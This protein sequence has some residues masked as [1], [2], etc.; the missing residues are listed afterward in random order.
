MLRCH[1]GSLFN[2]PPP[3]SSSLLSSAA[4]TRTK[5]LRDKVRAKRQQQ[6]A[7]DSAATAAMQPANYNYN[8][9]QPTHLSATHP[10][11]HQHT[12]SHSHPPHPHSHP[13]AAGS[14]SHDGHD[15][16][17][18]HSVLPSVHEVQQPAAVAPSQPTTSTALTLEE[19]DIKM[20]FDGARLGLLD[21]LASLL[22]TGHITPQH[23]DQAFLIAA[24]HGHQRL[25]SLLLPKVSS[26]IARTPR[27]D[28]ALHLSAAHG[29]YDIVDLLCKVSTGTAIEERNNAGQTPLYVAVDNNQAHVVA[30]LLEKGAKVNAA[31]AARNSILHVAAA[32]GYAPIVLMVLKAGAVLTGMNDKDE[33]ALEVSKNSEICR[34]LLEFTTATLTLDPPSSTPSLSSHPATSPHILSPHLPT[35]I[36]PFRELPSGPSSYLFWTAMGVGKDSYMFQNFGVFPFDR[37]NDTERIIVLTEVAEA[38][39][40]YKTDLKGN[41]LNESALYAVFA[42]MKA[43]IK[44]ELEDGE[45][46]E[47]DEQE[48]V[49]WRKRVLEAYQQVYGVDA[50]VCGLSLDCFKR[51]VWNTVV[52]LLARSLFGESFW[53][54]KRMFLSPNG[55]ERTSLLRHYRVDVDYFHCRLPNTASVEIQLTFKKLIT[56]SKT[57]LCDDSERTSSRPP[58]AGC[59]CQECIAELEVP[60]TFKLQFLEEA[61]AEKRKMKKGRKGTGS[62]GGGGQP[63]LS[64]GNGTA[65]NNSTAVTVA[66]K[67]NHKSATSSTALTPSHSTHSA[68]SP[69]S[70]PSSSSLAAATAVDTTRSK[71]DDLII[72]QRKELSNFFC[73]PAVD[74]EILTDRGFLSHA[75]VRSLLVSHC[76]LR[77]ACP[78]MRRPGEYALQYHSFGLNELIEAESE[79]LVE[80]RCE[81][82]GVDLLVTDNHRMLV[83]LGKAD[84]MAQQRWTLPYIRADEVVESKE[85]AIQLLCNASC[86]LSHVSEQRRPSFSDL[87]GL[88]SV[89][90]EDAFIELYSCWHTYGRVHEIRGSRVACFSVRSEAEGDEVEAAM[91]RLP[92]TRGETWWREK[93]RVE[94]GRRANP[95]MTGAESSEEEMEDDSCSNPGPI[96]HRF[97]ISHPRWVSYFVASRSWGTVKASKR[98]RPASRTITRRV[99]LSAESI[100][101][102]GSG[103]DSEGDSE[104]SIDEVQEEESEDGLAQWASCLD[105]HQLRLLIRGLHRCVGSPVNESQTSLFAESARQADDY[106]HLCLIAGYTAVSECEKKEGI[107]QWVVHYTTSDTA[108][109]P[110]LT[111]NPTTTHQSKHVRSLPSSPLTSVWCIS[112]PTNEHLLI[113]RRKHQSPASHYAS[114]PVIVGNSSISVEEKWLLTEMSTAELSEI[115]SQASEWETLRAALASY[116]QYAWEEDVLEI[117]DDCFAESDTRV[118]TDS[119]LLYVDEI[120]ARMR[121]GERVTYACY[122]VDSEAL[123]YR[124]GKLV[125]P[126][127]K[128]QQQLLCF[129]AEEQRECEG[130]EKEAMLRVTP[131]HRM[132]VRQP[133]QRRP[134]VVRASTLHTPCRCNSST[135]PCLHRSA[136]FS[137]LNSAQHGYV[138]PSRRE[139]RGRAVEVQRRAYLQVVGFALH[140]RHF[141]ATSTQHG[142][143][144]ASLT[145]TRLSPNERAWLIERCAVAGVDCHMSGEVAAVVLLPRSHQLSDDGANGECVSVTRA[146]SEDEVDSDVDSAF[147]DSDEDEQRSDDERGADSSR[148]PWWMLRLSAAE[149]R[150]VVDGL[151][152]ANGSMHRR[153]IS[154]HDAMFCERLMHAL[155]HCGFSPLCSLSDNAWTISWSDMADSSDDVDCS[156]LLLTAGGITSQPYSQSSDGRIWCISVDHPDHLIVAQRATRLNGRITRQWRPLITGN[157]VT[158]ADDM[159]EDGKGMSDMLEAML[160]AVETIKADELTPPPHHHTNPASTALVPSHTSHHPHQHHSHHHPHPSASSPLSDEEWDKRGRQMLENCVLAE[161]AR[162]V[163]AQYLLKKQ[164]SKAQQVALE[165]ELELLQEEM[166]VKKG[167]AGEKKKKKKAAKRKEKATAGAP[168]AEEAEGEADEEKEEAVVEMAEVKEEKTEETE[169]QRPTLA[170]EKDDEKDKERKSE[171]GR[172]ADKAEKE[173]REASKE[174]TKKGKEKEKKKKQRQNSTVTTLDRMLSSSSSS[175][176]KAKPA[177]SSSTSSSSASPASSLPV[178]AAPSPSSSAA[179]A[180][181]KEAAKLPPP[182]TAAVVN[183]FAMLDEQAVK[184]R[185]QQPSTTASSTQ[186]AVLSS[187]PSTVKRQSSETDDAD[188]MLTADGSAGDGLVDGLLLVITKDSYQSFLHSHQVGLSRQQFPIVRHLKPLRTAVL[189]F[190]ASDRSVHGVYQCTGLV[191]ENVNPSAFSGTRVKAG[192]GRSGG[193]GGI[194]GVGYS[195]WMELK[196]MDGMEV[197]VSE[198]VVRG[199]FGSDGLKA[200]KVDLKLVK[201]V[202]AAS[203]AQAGKR[204]EQ[205]GRQPATTQRPSAS[206]TGVVAVTSKSASATATAVT[207]PRTQPPVQQRQTSKQPAPPATPTTSATSSAAALPAAASTAAP[208][209][210]ASAA[211]NSDASKSTAAGPVKNVWK[212]RQE[213]KASEQQPSPSATSTASVG[214]IGSPLTATATAPIGSPLVAAVFGGG[215]IINPTIT[216]IPSSL[217]GSSWQ[218]SAQRAAAVNHSASAA[219]ATP[220]F[221][222]GQSWSAIAG[223]RVAA[224]GGAI[225]TVGAPASPPLATVRTLS[226]IMPISSVVPAPSMTHVPDFDIGQPA[227]AWLPPVTHQPP[228]QLIV[229]DISHT[230]HQHQQ[231]W[232]DEQ[233]Q[234]QQLM[235]GGHSVPASHSHPSSPLSSR[236]Y[237]SAYESASHDRLP[238]SAADAYVRTPPISPLRAVGSLASSNSFAPPM[239][240]PAASVPQLHIHSHSHTGL[241]THQHPHSMPPSP[242]NRSL[243]N[244]GMPPLH[245]SMVVGRP[246][247]PPSLMFAPMTVGYG[248]TPSP[249]PAFPPQQPM[250]HP[251]PPQLSHA[252]LPYSMPMAYQP[253]HAMYDEQRR[254]YEVEEERRFEAAEAIRQQQQQEEEREREMMRE[255]EREMAAAARYEEEMNRGMDGL[256]LHMY[257]PPAH[258]QLHQSPPPSHQPHIPHPHQLHSLAHFRPSPAPSIDVERDELD[259]RQLELEMQRR[260]EAAAAAS[261]PLRSTHGHF[262]QSPSP[263]SSASSNS[264]ATLS[265]LWG[266]STASTLSSSTWGSAVWSAT[267]ASHAHSSAMLNG[268]GS[269][270]GVREDKLDPWLQKDEPAITGGWASKPAAL[271]LSDF[272]GSSVSA[273]KST[274]SLLSSL[275]SIPNSYGSN[276]AGSSIWGTGGAE[277]SG[278]GGAGGGMGPNGGQAFAAPPLLVSPTSAGGM[279]GLKGKAMGGFSSDSMWSSS[280]QSGW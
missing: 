130:D 266:S 17:V 173:Q 272:T 62:G 58:T 144:A 249:H 255:R 215:V 121:R 116:A 217:Q 200:R 227:P 33:T 206:V 183:P 107:S 188:T 59:F 95:E 122:E 243:F 199:L 239:P 278:A 37:L 233:Q 258:M 137:M 91:H 140:D 80:F 92:L 136:P 47:A 131:S 154:T 32:N 5:Q 257:Q 41:L 126:P 259:V 153:Q 103:E 169:M 51:T 172:E 111:I 190:N 274:P 225:D 133:G 269:G 83:R 89:D 77:I 157:C 208:T 207:Q 20:F 34:L 81:A 181:A 244:S 84:A 263:T 132:L 99:P 230:Q 109:R 275:P 222:P 276:F 54:K 182:V 60:L 197:E 213:Q 128:R 71:L 162:K 247:P 102:L 203:K 7:A 50:G 88:T 232:M 256:Q 61:A 265:S 96:M 209:A 97:V 53:E 138:S 160:D 120:E 125:F 19:S 196:S 180:K 237:E 220:S 42:L 105:A 45:L 87:L 117:S 63:A 75:T 118:L 252:S 18:A 189:L 23:I 56:M 245:P 142:K 21:H 235:H 212:L 179:A 115:I 280:T 85:E 148:P 76:P 15:Y 66:G 27:G 147:T 253:Q 72:T 12:H 44:R 268:G 246:A 90:E 176:I 193:G 68:A 187:A 43:R 46:L 271:S 251:P 48:S 261:I 86:G 31:D 55:F 152:Y 250:Y 170:E 161:F 145:F 110:V 219:A 67:S 113:V 165:L 267:S 78:V 139:R 35:P 2:L 262:S 234:Q 114:R 178:S 185:V 202:A 223:A 254:Q 40:G 171:E 141:C 224:A 1:S 231:Q 69:R 236:S 108:A 221:A 79:R 16:H 166:A 248:R 151:H 64:A 112:V 104:E 65:G 93:T 241:S 106:V 204:K 94:G 30:L 167:K 134:R 100:Q 13:T 205:A 228:P 238:I 192:V 127:A 119:G 101:K 36:S 210:V 98:I 174:E 14:L 8:T 175:A 74:H 9:T 260:D 135:Q 29:H 3:S 186:Q 6:R 22:D 184:K 24:E 49:V 11:T 191:G 163:A 4:M 124:P 57:F 279:G 82:S 218:S 214:P 52:N 155:L 226:P 229:D 25:L 177:S 150:C 168:K 201:D 158:I 10:H 149:L 240:L 264:K 70:L 277:S 39:S 26:L 143:E 211:A 123:C 146:S 129:T 216:I 270:S 28:T 38:M 194:G 242:S 164:E 159:C 198:S 195:S 273:G 73:F 156:P